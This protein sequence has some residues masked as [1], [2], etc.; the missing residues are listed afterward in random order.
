LEL[1]Q[2]QIHQGAVLPDPADGFPVAIAAG[3]GRLA[4]GPPAEVRPTELALAARALI[5]EF[6]AVE[7]SQLGLQGLPEAQAIEQALAGVGQGVGPLAPAQAGCIEGIVELNVPAHLGQGQGRQAAGGTGPM[8]ACSVHR[9]WLDITGGAQ[10]LP[11]EAGNSARGLIIA[12][13][14]RQP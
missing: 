4:P 10:D 3:G 5:P 7:G 13:G 1:L 9:H 8:H 2:Q 6:Q 11:L 14:P 12:E